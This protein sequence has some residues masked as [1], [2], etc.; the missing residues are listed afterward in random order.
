MSVEVDWIGFNGI[1]WIISDISNP[2][3]NIN[4][5]SIISKLSSVNNIKVTSISLDIL[6]YE[7]IFN[8]SW[9]DLKWFL[10]RVESATSTL[11]IKRISIPIEEML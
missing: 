2:I 10:D 1:E 5:L 11:G 3:L 8:Q 6:M 9:D 7:P 4:N